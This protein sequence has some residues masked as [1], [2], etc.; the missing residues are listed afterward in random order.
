M[1]NKFPRGV[2]VVCSA[3]IEDSSGQILLTK[4]PKWHNQWTFPGGHI[5]PGEKISDAVTREAEEETGLQIE[6]V[7]IVAYGELINPKNFHRP[8]HLIYFDFYCKLKGGEV[9]LEER[10][11]TEYKWVLPEEALKLD[12]AEGYPEAIQ[13]FI[14]YKNE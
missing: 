3:I 10:E 9:K 2:E 13:K 14:K 4:S 11:L 8:A 6:P 1:S 12:L 5:E 7:E